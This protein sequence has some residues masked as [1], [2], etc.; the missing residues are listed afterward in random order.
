MNKRYALAISLAIFGI[1]AMMAKPAKPG[2]RTLTQPD[3]SKIQVKVVGDENLHFTTTPDGDLLYI[4]E[5]GFYHPGALDDDGAVIKDDISPLSIG[6]TLKIR[7]IKDIDFSLL[8]NRKSAKRNAPQS[9]IGLMSNACPSTGSPRG[10]II[11]VEYTDVKFNTSYNAKEYFEDMIN[12]DNFTQFGG[13]GSALQ[14]FKDQSHGKF[15]PQFDI[16]GPITLPQNQAYYG[17]NDRWG[18]DQ[19]AHMMVKHAVDILDPQVDFRLY[20]TN[21]DKLIDNIYI[22]Y[23][24]QGE[25]DFGDS[26]T[27]W[28]HAWDMRQAGIR[29]AADGVYLGRYACSNEWMETSPDGMGTF[30]HEFSHVLGLPDLYNTEDGNA[31]YTPGYYSVLDLG[32]YNN[33]SRTPCNYG[34]YELNALGWEEPIELRE[35][36]SLILPEI[37]TGKFCLIPTAKATEFFLIENR[38]LTGWD[39]YLANH[40]M[41]IWH[42][43]FVQSTFDSNSVNTT[44]NRQQVDILE[45]NNMPGINYEE[46]YTFPGTT[47]KTVFSSSTKPALKDWAGIEIDIPLTNIREIDGNIHFD[48][49]GGGGNEVVAGT[50]DIVSSEDHHPV[51]YNLQGVRINNPEKGMLLIE[52]KG[53]INRKVIF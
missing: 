37:S 9:G 24:G 39:T 15:T 41:L 42:I 6:Q 4:D 20:D 31:D 12:G 44:K 2:L 43:D 40:G 46:G 22:I 53:G 25:A 48:V 23:A 38:Q 14:Y 35:P 26:N 33:D 49:R 36:Q 18:D 34:A 16:Y 11:L 45:A 8:R 27:V 30:V 52:S 29:Q 10:L 47:G 28:P 51:Y 5:N 7:N 32:N 13:T 17:K 19:N 50:K 21:D 1:C 3:G